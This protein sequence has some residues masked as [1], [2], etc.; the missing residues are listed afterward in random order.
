MM[1]AYSHSSQYAKDFP[2]MYFRYVVDVYGPNRLRDIYEAPAIDSLYSKLALLPDHVRE[3]LDFPKYIFGFEPKQDSARAGQMMETYSPYNHLASSAPPTLMIHG[4]KDRVV[5]VDQSI[6]LQAKLDSLG[7]ENEIHIVDG[8]DHAFA[9][10]TPEQ[11][12]NLQKWIVEF[13]LRYYSGE[14]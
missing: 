1:V 10:A 9:N 6:R 13:V 4:D 12:E 11:K 8:A 14:K 3:Q 5:P 7:I 2:P